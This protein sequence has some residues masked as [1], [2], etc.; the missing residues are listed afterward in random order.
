MGGLRVLAVMAVSAVALMAPAPTGAE[1]V[2]EPVVVGDDA[3]TT[4]ARDQRSTGPRVGE[5]RT[6]PVPE[7]PANLDL[8]PP[9]LGPGGLHLPRDAADPDIVVVDGTYYLYSTNTSAARV[10]VWRSADLVTWRFLGDA[11]PELPQWADAGGETTWAPSV[12]RVGPTYNLYF[13]GFAAARGRFCIGVATASDAAGPFRPRGHPLVCPPQAGGAIDPYLFRDPATGLHLLY[14]TDE[15]CCGRPAQLWTRRLTAN[16]QKA[17]GRASKLLTAG[18]EW[19]DG[20]V[21]GPTM[22]LRSG[23]YHLLYSGNWW[24]THHYAIGHAVCQSV[25][26]PCYR[27]SE[28]PFMTNRSDGVGFGGPS[29]WEAP[30]GE[31]WMSYHG[32]F[33]PGVGYENG[34]VRAAFAH[35]LDFPDWRPPPTCFGLAA[36]VIGS[37]R[38]ETLVGTPGRDVIVGRGGADLIDG[39]GG[40]DVL[41][42]G[43]GNDEIRGGAGADRIDAG[44]G[45]DT[46]GGGAGKDTLDGGPG[47]DTVWGGLGRDVVWGGGHVD[48]CW[49]EHIRCETK[50]RTLH[51]GGRP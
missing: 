7:P 12:H 9:R 32:W 19:E 35:R 34:G 27:S 46:A 42:G 11:L 4:P 30:S 48:E 17:R 14:K 15:N 16:G 8:R 25:R 29:V 13:S 31:V 3:D 6:P 10:P 2:P 33:G 40:D 23:R 41:C 24:N 39:R 28:D 43:P 5:T 45:Q 18:A 38:A 21:E 22:V 44:H 50:H 49:G 1:P 20:V 51:D 36:T 47:N 37:S 26:G